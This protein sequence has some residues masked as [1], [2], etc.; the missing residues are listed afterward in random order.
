[1]NS[2]SRR[3]ATYEEAVA[4]AQIRLSTN[5]SLEGV[6]V[7]K[8]HRLVVLAKDFPGKNEVLQHFVSKL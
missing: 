5:S 2:R 3:Y 8:A 7:M 4:E 6:Y 1:M